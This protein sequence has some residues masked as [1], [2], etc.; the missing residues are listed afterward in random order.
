MYAFPDP[1]TSPHG[2]NMTSRSAVLRQR[3][4]SPEPPPARRE[5]TAMD[6]VRGESDTLG[7]SNPV[8]CRPGRLPC[9]VGPGPGPPQWAPSVR[10]AHPA[11]VSSA[12]LARTMNLSEQYMG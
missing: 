4:R 3:V 1:N 2:L 5:S 9:A 10:I 11:L 8:S 7:D 6:L 12:G